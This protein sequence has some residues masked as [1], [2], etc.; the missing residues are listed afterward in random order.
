MLSYSASGSGR[1]VTDHILG[2]CQQ[3]S[4]RVFALSVHNEEREGIDAAARAL[5]RALSAPSSSP[6]LPR[7][8]RALRGG[9]RRAFLQGP[10]ERKR[11]RLQ[12][13]RVRPTERAFSRVKFRGCALQPRGGVER[14]PD[15]IRAAGLLEGLREQGDVTRGFRVCDM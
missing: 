15:L 5:P 10:G 14:G 8:W 11:S 13:T 7:L 3:T 9:H 1:D 4:P 2:R 6:S 12:R